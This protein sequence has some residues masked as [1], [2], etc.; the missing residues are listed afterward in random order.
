MIKEIEYSLMGIDKKDIRDKLY[1]LSATKV[2]DEYL[3][4]RAVFMIEPN[5]DHR[6]I[7]VRQEYDKVTVT[8]KNKTSNNFAKEL[9][10]IV[11]DFDKTV[12][13]FKLAGK[14]QEQYI[15]NYREKYIYND[16]EIV[17]DTYP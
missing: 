4:K 11:N 7:R 9:E 15:E 8:Y 16:L 2:Y 14:E 6:F 3:Q 5:S 13:I 12:E 17:I 1:S 10:I